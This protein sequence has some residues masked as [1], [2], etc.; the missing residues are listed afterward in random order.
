MWFSMDIVRYILILLNYTS[1]NI[2][3][4]IVHEL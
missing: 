3:D 1:S 4:M 2:K